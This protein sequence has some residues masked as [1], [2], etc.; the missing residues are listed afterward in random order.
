MAR[1]DRD[2]SARRILRCARDQGYYRFVLS[3]TS[4]CVLRLTVCDVGA[5]A[6]LRKEAFVVVRTSIFASIRGDNRLDLFKR[7]IRLA[8]VPE[9]VRRRS[10]LCRSTLIRFLAATRS[11]HSRLPTRLRCR[12]DDDHRFPQRRPTHAHRT[13]QQGSQTRK[14]FARVRVSFYVARR[15]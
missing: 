4:L 12:L 8:V 9:S 10:L 13:C 6:I 7:L 1:I 15:I 11:G 14:S 3:I 2:E 5:G